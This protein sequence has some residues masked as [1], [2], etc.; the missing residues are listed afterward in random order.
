MNFVWFFVIIFV[1]INA[2]Q[3]GLILGL[4]PSKKNGLIIGAIELAEFPLLVL[5]ISNTAA[6]GFLVIVLTNIAQWVI[7][8]IITL[9]DR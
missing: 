2:V 9:G 4:R 3:T 7:I 1:I 6:L 8:G 5:L